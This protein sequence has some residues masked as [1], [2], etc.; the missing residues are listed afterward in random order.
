MANC[1]SRDNR[2]GIAGRGGFAPEIADTVCKIAGHGGSELRALVSARA[3]A[4]AAQHEVQRALR[5]RVLD[6]PEAERAEVGCP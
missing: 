1:P 4:V 3:R 6:D 2:S 5:R